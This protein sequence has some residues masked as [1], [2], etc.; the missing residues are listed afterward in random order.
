MT[1]GEI[2][3]HVPHLKPHYQLRDGEVYFM[4]SRRPT[5][6]LTP[7]EISLYL[8]IDGRKTVVELERTHCGAGRTLLR[9]REASILE[10]IHPISSP[11][12]PHL[13]VIEPHMDDAVLSVGGRLLHRRGRCRITIVSVVRRSNFTSYLFLSRN[14]FNLGDVTDLRNKESALAARLLGAEHLSLDWSDAPTR[15]WPAERWCA[16]TVQTFQ[17][18]PGAFVKLIPDA[19]EVSLLAQELAQILITL[20]PDELWIPM[21]TGDHLDH[22]TTRSACLRML[23]DQP[24][25]FA[26]VRVSMYED[27]P[28]ATDGHAGHI[29]AAIA[30]EGARVTRA[31]EDITDVFDDKLRLASLYASQFKRSYIEPVLRKCAGT[32]GGTRDKFAETYYRLE[33]LT[34][35]P[36]EWALS[37]EHEG[38]EK[39]YK[40]VEALLHE[41]DSQQRIV[42]M[43]LPSGQVGDWDGVRTNL[44][45]TFP[46]AAFEIYIARDAAWQVEDSF[47][48]RFR[49]LI[50]GRGAS[51]WVGWLKVLAHEFV[52]PATT[53]V[54]WRGA[55]G[56]A[57]KRVLKKLINFS[58][59]LPLLRRRV[60]FART[61]W[62][63]RC[64]INAHTNHVARESRIADVGAA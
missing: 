24:Q 32:A 10:L 43:I 41:S 4:M 9:W 58:V 11:A 60:I 28:Y 13:V 61:L 7:E 40:G 45:N 63:F 23:A 14:F 33:N 3:A 47:Q 36:G 19:T 16:A 20:G 52:T 2:S 57:P 31:A 25:R 44:L 17:S 21:G 50:V 5:L 35:T 22:R 62:D 1:P 38:V 37:R 29:G 42:V 49:V 55:Y 59:K 8:A 54:L 51:S 34:S 53:I 18:A 30:A 64:A 48:G 26:D 39:L 12:F 6:Q 46:N 56:G 15:F 27:L